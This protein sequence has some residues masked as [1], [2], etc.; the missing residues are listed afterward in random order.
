MRSGN[1]NGQALA[2]FI[3]VIPLF[4][5]VMLG[6]IQ[7]S[8]LYFA[9]Q[10]VHYASFAATRA[11]IVR[12]CAAIHPDDAAVAH[13]TP[14]VF[15]AATLA[16]TVA[17]PT[18]CLVNG[19]VLSGSRNPCLPNDLDPSLSFLPDLPDSD[20]ATGLGFTGDGL[21]S[22]DLALTKF[23]NA[24]WLTSVQ[25]VHHTELGVRPVEWFPDPEG[26]GPGMP[27]D[28]PAEHAQNV[29]APGSD[30]T[31][32]VTL[33]YPMTVPL[34]NRVIF[35]IFV[36]FSDLAQERLNLGQIF[37]PGGRPEDVMV[38]PKRALAP[39]NRNAQF[40]LA[41]NRIFLEFGFSR[42]ARTHVGM[43][44]DGL[45]ERAWFPVP[46]RARCTLTTEGAMY[47]MDGPPTTP[48]W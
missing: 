29:P 3:L 11:A 8:L 7:F 30:L 32:E 28:G 40:A 26:P 1:A 18:Q 17:M 24:A 43:I 36:N 9:Y 23:I 44:A 15:T 6:V 45:A 31:L 21:P 38:H 35:G 16:T 14:A 34:V 47:P 2:E 33:I 41:L 46:V 39:L 42:A 4:F 12:P 13:F 48:G 5:V 19:V 20:E 25:R 22:R 10:M 37:G 27:C